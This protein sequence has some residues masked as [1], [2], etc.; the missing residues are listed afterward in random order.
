MPHA[1]SSSPAPATPPDDPALLKQI[2]IEQQQTLADQQRRIESLEHAMNVLLRQVTG[3]KQERF[4][5]DQ[6]RLFDAGGAADE[7]SADE[8]SG[9]DD[10][11]DPPPGGGADQSPKSSKRRGHGRRK[12]PEHLPRRRMEHDLNDTD[13]SCPCCGE[14]REKIGEEISEQL[15]YEPA[16]L[17]VVEHVRCKYAC[18]TC[19]ANVQRAAKPPQPI[20]KGLPGPGLLAHI[21]LSKYGDHLPLYRQEDILLRHGVLIRRSTQCGWVAAACDLVRPLYD[22]MI[23]LVLQSRVIH[24]DDTSVKMLDAQLD[25]ARTARLWAYIGDAAHPYSVFDFTESRQRDGPQSFLS[26]YR[27]YLQADAYGGYDGI[28]TGSNGDI[29]EVGCWA[30]TRRYFFNAKSSDSMRAHEA[31]ARIARLYALEDELADAPEVDRAAARQDRATPLLNSFRNWMDSERDL[32]LPKSPI[33][34]AFTYATNQWDALTRYPEAGFLSVDNNTAERTMKLPAIGRKNWLF[35]GNAAGGDR[36][37]ILM[38]LIASCKANQVEP[39][40]YLKD[41]FTRLP[42]SPSSLDDFLPD[43]WLQHHPEHCWQIDALRQPERSR[44]SRPAVA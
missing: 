19:E 32:V 12:L 1:S 37:A 13:R 24:T 27:G 14:T 11:T 5:P 21:V 42:E 25:H 4:D 20:D 34:S 3:P 41:V 26:G 17:F 8:T 38:S 18:S 6:L 36:A 29:I 23:E 39:S 31:A 43:I 16:S 40:A 15:E 22:R 44:R 33:G 35:V 7:S 10:P 9:D 30:H 2:V 28:Y